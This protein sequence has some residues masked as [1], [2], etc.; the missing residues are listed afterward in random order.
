MEEEEIKEKNVFIEDEVDE[1]DN[2]EDDNGRYDVDFGFEGDISDGGE[3]D[4]SVDEN[5]VFSDDGLFLIIFNYKLKK[6]YKKFK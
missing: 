3:S 1:S 2:G 5:L 6:K 4:N